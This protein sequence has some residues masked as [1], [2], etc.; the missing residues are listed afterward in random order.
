[1]DSSQAIGGSETDASRDL[2]TPLGNIVLCWTT[3]GFIPRINTNKYGSRTMIP[4]QLN[5]N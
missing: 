1:M 4:Q 3:P 5:A 2:K